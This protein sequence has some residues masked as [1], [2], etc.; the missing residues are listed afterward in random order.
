MD[1]IKLHCN[2]TIKIMQPYLYNVYNIT[3]VYE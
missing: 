2:N 1:T 3:T